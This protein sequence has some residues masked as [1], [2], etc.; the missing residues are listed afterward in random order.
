MVVKNIAII[1]VT[2]LVGAGIGYF[3]GRPCA[4][5]N[6]I[7]GNTMQHINE[8]DLDG[9]KQAVNDYINAGKQ[10]R[11]DI[12]RP[13][14]YKDA[15]IYSAPNGVVSGGSME[16]LFEFLDEKPAATEMVAE[17]TNIDIAG[18]VAYAKVESDNWH[19]ERYTDMFLLVRDGDKWKLLTKVFH[20]H[21][22]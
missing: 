22:K 9:V 5:N 2:L 12:L 8:H 10:G 3:I 14:V 18:D 11:A 19:G 6:N 20:T 17:I 7:G 16:S 1:A 4:H 15:I 21:A 13:S